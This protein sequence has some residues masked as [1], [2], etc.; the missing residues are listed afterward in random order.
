MP[1]PSIIVISWE[2]LYFSRDFLDLK[3]RF[4]IV[5]SIPFYLI[6]LMDR[7]K[8]YQSKITPLESWEW[9][10]EKTKQ[11]WSLKNKNKFIMEDFFEFQW[12]GKK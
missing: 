3:W 4:L 6:F 7:Y 1:V 12:N 5:K 8:I 2:I 11:I 10:I 9:K